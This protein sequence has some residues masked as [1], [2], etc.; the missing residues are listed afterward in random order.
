MTD[1]QLKLLKL[2]ILSYFDYKYCIPKDERF[3]NEIYYQ[4][5]NSDKK[6]NLMRGGRGSAKSY[7]TSGKLP[8]VLISCLPF[9]RILVIRQIEQRHITS[10]YQEMLDYIDFWKLR[11][12]FKITLRPLRIE[13]LETG[14]YILFRGMDKPDSVKSI[15]DVTHVIWEEAFE[16]K[17]WKGVK[18]IDKSVR[19]PKLKI[20]S[21][22]RHY[23]TFNPDNTNHWLYEVFYDESEEK[24]RQYRYFRENA[25]YMHTTYKDNKFLPEAFIELIEADKDADPERFLVDGLGQWGRLRE[26]GL[27][28]RQFDYVKIV[29]EGLKDRVY[30]SKAP[31]HITFDFNVYPY[32]SLAISQL[33]YDAI[34]HQIQACTIDEICLDDNASAGDLRKTLIAFLQKYRKHTGNVVVCGDRAGHSRKTNSIPDFATIFAMLQPTPKNK[35]QQHRTQTGQIVSVNPYPEY[36]D[37]GCIFKMIDNTIYSQNPRLVLRQNFFER[38]HLGQ[39]KVLPAHKNYGTINSRGG[40]RPLSV[41]YPDVQIVQKIDA[42]CKKTIKDYMELKEDVL[43]GGKST[44]DKDLGHISDALDYQYCQWFDAELAYMAKELKL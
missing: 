12:E 13:H 9:C 44:R 43:K 42:E 26:T 31:L 6:Y 3:D 40:S 22:H 36:E 25:L 10:T 39:L 30:D 19:T 8:I 24:K 29:E 1:R 18:T 21:P 35:Y 5:Y 4:L 32:I 27:F 37:L 41:Q 23:F 7:E 38:L 33:H 17:D 16:I 20:G 28:Y 34:E 2:D 11:S 14:N 15:K